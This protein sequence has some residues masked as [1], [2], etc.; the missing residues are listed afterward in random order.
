VRQPRQTAGSA[1]RRDGSQIVVLQ[2]RQPLTVDL[3]EAFPADLYEVV[4]LRD[5]ALEPA[6]REDAP[7]PRLE[8]IVTDRTGWETRLRRMARQGPVEVVTNDEYCVEPCARLRATLGLVPRHPADPLRYLDKI[9]MKERLR[10]AGVRVPRYHAF[11]PVVRDSSDTRREVTRAVGL[12]AVVKPRREANS[13]GVQIID[14]ETGLRDWLA[15]HDGESG[16]QVEEH[17]AGS[18]YHVNALVRNGRME[19]VQVGA[20]LGPL[21][22]LHG[23]GFFG[24]FTIP[25]ADRLTVPARELNRR[26]VAALGPA[27]A[28]VVHTEFVVTAAGEPVVLETAARAPGALVSEMARV[29]SGL[30]LE[31]ANLRLQAG[32]AVPPPTRRDLSAAWLWVAVRPGERF[33]GPPRVHSEHRLHLTLA[34]RHGN[35][36]DSTLVGA[37]LL[38]WNTDLP[39]LRNDIETARDATWFRA[40]PTPPQRPQ[41]TEARKFS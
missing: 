34:G 24:G 12:P 9:T 28:F 11:A 26:V 36:G 6:V 19:H 1:D 33:T 39:G 3:R 10:A 37:S 16:W 4:V 8:S 31:V 5:G 29:H 23:Q 40:S 13:R 25:A 32:L 21:L 17:L 27:G 15:A 14:S 38:L 22:D 20:Y 7:G 41:T 2:S 35:H 30:N 18:L